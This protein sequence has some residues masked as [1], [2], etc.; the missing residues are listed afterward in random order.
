ML[1]QRLF[2][3][4]TTLRKLRFCLLEF[5]RCPLR[6]L[7]LF[8]FFFTCDNDNCSVP[9]DDIK[10]SLGFG[11]VSSPSL[12]CARHGKSHRRHA[13]NMGLAKWFTKNV[14]TITVP[15]K[16]ASQP[17]LGTLGLIFSSLNQS[18]HVSASSS[19]PFSASGRKLPYAGQSM[20][21][22]QWE[23][24]WESIWDSLRKI[25]YIFL[26]ANAAY[27]MFSVSLFASTLFFFKIELGSGS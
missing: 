9:D 27:L 16:P 25:F 26:P 11:S 7:R 1:S 15:Q 2:L 20:K 12:W 24:H 22:S 5:Y 14:I 10:S 23:T 17:F 13:W 3:S 21:S 4:M 6:G 18:R 8:A 19:E